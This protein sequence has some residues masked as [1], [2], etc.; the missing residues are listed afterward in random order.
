MFTSYFAKYKGENG[1]SIAGRAPKGFCG[2]EFKTLAPKYWF[3]KRHKEDGDWDFYKEQYQKQ[4]LGLLDPEEVAEELGPDAVL[5]CWE[6]SGNCHRH[7]VA[8]W[9]RENGYKVEE[10]QY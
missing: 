1:V 5:L 7:L 4:V 9:L 3:F 8:E 10:L 6:S 2:R